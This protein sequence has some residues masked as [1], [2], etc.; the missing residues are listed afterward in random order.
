M[1]KEIA[2]IDHSTHPT[3]MPKVEAPF[4]RRTNQNGEYILTPEINEGYEWVFE[5]DDVIATEKIDGTNVSVIVK[6]GCITSVWNR[7]N[8]VKVFNKHRHSIVKGVLRSVKRGYTELPDGQWF[9]E[10]VG[11]KVQGNPYNLDKHIW[12]PFKHYAWQR[13]R[14][15]W[16]GKYP[17]TYEA[18][19]KG[20]KMG[21]PPL[22]YARRHGMS[23]DEAMEKNA[24]VEGVVF[25]APDGR[26]AKLREDMFDFY[27]SQ[28]SR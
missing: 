23:L 16:W 11:P 19:R 28:E 10:V 21:L 27:Y 2:Q 13:L 5:N 18:L 9:G 8:R 12:I 25:V 15:N 22:F 14:Y 20:F 24:Y 26:L 4:V 17:K 1:N 3:D 7:K 6:N